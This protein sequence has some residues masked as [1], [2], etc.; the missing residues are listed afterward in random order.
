MSASILRVLLPLAIFGALANPT[1][2]NSD[3]CKNVDD[4]LALCGAEWRELPADHPAG[5]SV[6]TDGTATGKIIVQ[7]STLTEQI[8]A[9]DVLDMAVKSVVAS[10]P[11]G[12]GLT[13]E[14]GDVQAVGGG[15]FATISYVA[16]YAHQDMHFRHT[17]LVEDAHIIQIMTA[18][19]EA[20]IDT[21]N[22]RLM[23][24]LSFSKAGTTL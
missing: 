13:V 4:A 21:H 18:A 6:W 10:L 22:Q 24:A 9:E 14:N 12:V 15:L 23:S 1:L 3:I 8:T 19:G 11:D 7:L 16:E 5:I 20:D 17:I 2:A